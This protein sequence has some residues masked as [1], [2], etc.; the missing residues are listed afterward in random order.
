MKKTITIFMSLIMVILMGLSLNAQVLFTE[1]FDYPVGDSLTAH[2]WT[3]HSGTT[4][5]LVT[6]GN[7]TYPGY[8]TQSGQSALITSAAS[9][10][11]NHTFTAPTS[12]SVYAA[13]LINVTNATTTGD[14]FFHFMTGTTTFA[15][16]VYIKKDATDATKFTI[17]VLKGSSA[18]S[19]VYSPVLM[20]MN[21]THLIVLKY[22]INSGSTTDDVVSLY[23]NPATSSEGT[24]TVVASD[25]TSTDLTS[26]GTIALRQG[27]ASVASTLTVD[28]LRVASS[29][30]DAIGFTGTVT[31]PVVTSGIA[32]GITQTSAICGGNVTAD[33]GAAITARGICYSTSA[34]PDI[35]GTKVPVTG[36]TGAFSGN[37][38]GL[39][40]N[41]LYHFRA[42]ATNSAGTSY[43]S[44]V[45]FTT[46]ASAVAPVVTTGAASAITTTT[47][48]VGGDVSNDGGSTITERGIC[49]STTLNP[50]TT[51]SKIA[52]TG[53][54]G[55]FSGNLTGLTGS[56]LYHARAYATN[57]IGTSYGADITFTTAVAAIPCANIAEL[58]AKP[59]DNSTLYQ[60]TGEA[61]I[62]YQHTSRNQKY[63]QDATAAIVIDDP[64]PAK[65]TTTYSIGNGITG[66]KGKLYNY[67]GLLE[68]VPVEDPGAPTSI[69][70]VITPLVLTAANM[71]DTTLMKA[72]QS[73]LV[74]LNAAAFTDA[75]GTMKFSTNKKYRL[76][77]GGT[78]DS[79]FY[80][81]SYTVDYITPTPLTVPSGQGFIIGNVNMSYNK[82][83]I[84][85][86]SKSDISLLTGIN[87]IEND[88]VG[89]Y[90]NP[91]NGKFTVS[92]DKINNGE[93][94]IY[95]MVGSLIVSQQINKGN[96]EFDLSSYGKGM[97]FINF[98]DSK[99]GK[100]WTEK[101][102][103]K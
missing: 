60:L 43:G 12:G 31:A 69:S 70:N 99:S 41:T 89:V 8:W 10:D 76:T 20:S 86:R 25:V 37:L 102:L 74:K 18:A 38:T 93:V 65:I 6:S 36:T 5:L 9:Q 54:T 39:T 27:S 98:T 34:N 19:T 100:S 55:T 66:I 71:M 49:W 92:L 46:A 68:F 35:S 26:V 88:V 64:S 67:F 87:E 94:K 62:T 78:T 3:A 95:S 11:V 63:I 85:A 14:Y 7:L 80:T 24:P 23:V 45:T 96:N 13:L 79:L 75:N 56:T 59:A 15:G 32:S 50:T 83:Y 61:V 101:L 29:W 1:Q 77:E 2:G 58:R 16:R 48:I 103:V 81:F 4:Q 97:Y 53:T 90:P 57:S 91:S 33:G 52:V 84:T 44:D 28:G 51:N 42:Y 82:Y 22:T 17:G 47:A 73:K 72:H 30:A 21:T 40:G